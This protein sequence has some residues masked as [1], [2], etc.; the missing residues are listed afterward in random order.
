M[1]LAED[2]AQLAEAAR[3]FGTLL[4]AELDTDQ[5][6][7]LR[8]PSVEACLSDLGI[9]L[10]AGGD[11]EA[12]ELEEL[13]ADFFALF[14]QPTE[15]APPVQ[16]VWAS[17]SF[18]GEPAACI[19]RH[20]DAAGVEFG[21][22]AARGAAVDHLGSILLLWAEVAVRPECAEIAEHI[23]SHHLAWGQQALAHAAADT[24]F[25]GQVS[26]ACGSLLS[27]LSA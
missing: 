16:S 18:E 14:L 11:G 23:E 2:R 3:L 6:S 20:A 15:G 9:E 10:P 19:R 17:G 27:E 7:E 26:R 4:I 5:L 8:E 12:K 24:G 21:R 13:A 22:L 25:Y 1:K